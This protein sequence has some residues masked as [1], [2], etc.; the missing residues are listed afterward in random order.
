MKVCKVGVASGE[1]GV[2]ADIMRLVGAAASSA[3]RHTTPHLPM[4]QVQLC[5][6]YLNVGSFFTQ[7]IVI[8]YNHTTTHTHTHT[9]THT[10]H[11]HTHT[12]TR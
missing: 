6:Q 7:F 9:P 8:R 3:L 12:H 5:V 11:T 10:T 2:R 1:V 4:L